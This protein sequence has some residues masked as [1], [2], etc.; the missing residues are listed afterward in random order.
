MVVQFIIPAIGIILDLALIGA[1][2]YYTGLLEDSAS[3]LEFLIMSLQTGASFEEFI[4]NCWMFILLGFFV[5]W[6]GLNLA[7]PKRRRGSRA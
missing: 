6:L 4:V 1:N 7:F 2:A 5:F 3:Q